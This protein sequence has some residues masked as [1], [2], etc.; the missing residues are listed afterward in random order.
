MA[1]STFMKSKYNTHRFCV[2][3]RSSKNKLLGNYISKQTQKIK[4]SSEKQR[5]PSVNLSDQNFKS[6]FIPDL[7][8]YY[9]YKIKSLPTR[10]WTTLHFRPKRF[11][12]KVSPKRLVRI[13]KFY[14]NKNNEIMSNWPVHVYTPD[15]KNVV[16]WKV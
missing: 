10:V 13:F 1:Y 15:W 11:F 3:N 6:N 2:H 16:A 7:V 9:I 14:A 8:F 5:K 4:L 12:K